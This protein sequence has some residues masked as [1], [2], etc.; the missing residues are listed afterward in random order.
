MGSIVV[1]WAEIISKGAI[2]GDFKIVKLTLDILELQMKSKKKGFGVVNI[3]FGSFLCSL[4]GGGN[5]LF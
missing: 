4:V 2:G 1:S 3:S 5:S